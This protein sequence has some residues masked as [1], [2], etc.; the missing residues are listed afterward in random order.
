MKKLI[1]KYRLNESGISLVEVIASIVILSV[2]LISIFTMLTQSG[3]TTKNNE[4]I[5]E[6]TYLAQTEMEKL[7]AETQ[8]KSYSDYTNTFNSLNYNAIPSS[9]DEFEKETTDAYY[10]IAVTKKDPTFKTTHIV[11]TISKEKGAKPK[12]QMQNTLKWS[13]P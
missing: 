5:V 12:A 10:K 8:S 3:R 7:Y 13:G 6:A 11:I 2:I 9:S 4:D 1:M